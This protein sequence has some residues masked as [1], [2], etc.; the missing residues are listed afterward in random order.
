[1]SGE[2]GQ[3]AMGKGSCIA[4]GLLAAGFAVVATGCGTTR[5]TDTSR[6]GTEQLLIS[7]AVDQAVS[8][9]D[10]QMLS[11]KKVFL[12]PKFLDGCTDKGYVV[13]TLRQHLLAH[14]CLL[15]D[16][17]K[18]ASYVVEARCGAIG[19]DRNDL[20]VGVP[21]IQ[22]PVA[23]PGYPSSVPEIPLAKRTD[24]KGVA[25]LAV[26]AYNR[27]TGRPVWQSGVVQKVSSSND[28]WVLGAG[29]FH[30]GTVGKTTELVGTPI[31]IPLLDTVP[32]TN[33]VQLASAVP[34]TRPAVWRE[35]PEPAPTLAKL[36]QPHGPYQL[37]VHQEEASPAKQEATESK[38]ERKTK[39]EK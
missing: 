31:P 38:E 14:G 30:H 8:E 35:P 33:E 2:G 12:E 34:V 29:P 18:E 1:M 23:V 25:K 15:M 32:A 9:M 39:S 24:Q 22:S 26:F 19:T 28:L 37:V 3:N 27:T 13:S 4:V 17:K 11:G 7:N 21:H 20:L 16:E 5:F 10:F 6:S 36:G